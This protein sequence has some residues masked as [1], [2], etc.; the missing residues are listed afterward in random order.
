LL[1]FSLRVQLKDRS[2]DFYHGP[3]ATTAMVATRRSS[4]E[5]DRVTFCGDAGE[6][7]RG[8]VRVDDNA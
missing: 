2:A 3:P 8:E 4:K 6:D 5:A 1:G 7:E